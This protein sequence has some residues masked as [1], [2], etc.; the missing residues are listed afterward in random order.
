MIKKILAIGLGA[1]ITMGAS[2][3]MATAIPAGL[4]LTSTGTPSAINVF[5]NGSQALYPI[6]S[7]GSLG[8]LPWVAIAYM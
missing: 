5:C 6:P 4:T 8:P 3:A 1:A 7:N 2:S